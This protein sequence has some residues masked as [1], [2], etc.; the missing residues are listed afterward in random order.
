M[1]DRFFA[2]VRRPSS[3]QGCLGFAGSCLSFA[4]GCFVFAGN[5]AI[6]IGISLVASLS[7]VVPGAALAGE[8]IAQAQPP[9][10][11][12]PSTSPSP[13]D[14]SVS[15]S[16]PFM[17]RLQTM[18]SPEI[19]AVL[20]ACQQGQGGVDL[21]SS[22]SGLVTCGDGSSVSDSAYTQYLSTLSDLMA[23]STLLGMRV[24]FS[25]DPRLKPEMATQ[26]LSSPQSAAPLRNALTNLL[27]KVGILSTQSPTSPGL[28][29]DEVM[30]RLLPMVQSTD[31]LT[32]L[33]GTPEQ[34]SQVVSQ[35]CKAP[36][37]SLEKIQQTVAMSSPQI[38]AV[39]L[40]EAGLADELQRTLR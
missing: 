31:N 35:F 24:A 9:Q 20:N 23:A 16:A 8:A 25:S 10:S 13:S 26:L 19:R 12:P 15:P 1:I 40:Q 28:L 37:T 18:F 33:L 38:Y 2:S 21:A 30:K 4:G 36:G 22:Q 39:C 27:G 34:Y 5:S 32:T 3:T 29:A 7:A 6:A 11:P 17:Q 14:A